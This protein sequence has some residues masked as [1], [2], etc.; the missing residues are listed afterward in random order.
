[1]TYTREYKVKLEETLTKLKMEII[2]V[3]RERI[4]KA[5]VAKE[6]DKSKK[7]EIDDWFAQQE[8][9][10]AQPM[11]HGANI[12]THKVIPMKPGQQPMNLQ[13]MRGGN[14]NQRT[15]ENSVPHEDNGMSY[16]ERVELL[17]HKII[18]TH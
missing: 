4:Q 15:R 9:Y 6:K 1:M 2:R 11:A 8:G 10:K 14:S 3:E 13:G 17:K 7:V 16:F 12:F 5:E 18:E